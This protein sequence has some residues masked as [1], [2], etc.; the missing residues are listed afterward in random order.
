MVRRTV[1]HNE[2][3]QG[4][5][6]RVGVLGVCEE[7]D[8]PLGQ[9]EPGLQDDCQPGLVELSTCLDTDE[10]VILTEV[11]YTRLDGTG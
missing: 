6:A 4:G 1:G 3:T 2:M 10:D 8:I 9:L 5:L 11:P 7:P